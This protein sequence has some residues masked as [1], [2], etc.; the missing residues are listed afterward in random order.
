MSNFDFGDFAKEFP[1]FQSVAHALDRLVE[2]LGPDR[3]DFLAYGYFVHLKDRSRNNA[4]IVHNGPENFLDL[5]QQ[6][7]GMATDIVASKIESLDAPFKID[8][9]MLVDQM[10]ERRDPRVRFAR[11][12]LDAGCRSAWIARISDIDMDGYG[13]LNHF[14]R[15]NADIPPIPIGELVPL[16][17]FFHQNAKKHGLLAKET[18]LTNVQTRTLHKLSQGKSALDIAHAEGVSTRAVEMRIDAARKKL[19]AHNSVE[20]VYKATAYG[21]LPPR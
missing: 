17:L 11:L 21:A 2:R 5:F 16:A 7:G 14:C 9:E 12:F 3:V 19:R 4:I 18:K 13:L 1:A 8:L 20:A 10:T 15:D 6:V